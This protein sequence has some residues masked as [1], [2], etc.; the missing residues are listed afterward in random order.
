MSAELDKILIKEAA[1]Q[2]KLREAEADLM[3]IKKDEAE[4]VHRKGQKWYDRQIRFGQNGIDRVKVK[5]AKLQGTKPA[6]WKARTFVAYAV[7]GTIATVTA[8]TLLAEA[9]IGAAALFA[10]AAFKSQVLDRDVLR[11]MNEDKENDQ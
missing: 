10:G 1:L 5:I 9:A 8:P 4:L 7:G 3:N 6:K 2:D 11:K